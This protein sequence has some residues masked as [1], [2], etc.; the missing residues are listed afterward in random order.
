MASE[1][2]NVREQSLLIENDFVNRQLKVLGEEEEAINKQIL[3]LKT[4]YEIEIVKLQNSVS[5]LTIE[6]QENLMVIEELER[7]LEIG[8]RRAEQ[9]EAQTQTECQTLKAQYYNS[10][11]DDLDDQSDYSEENE[12]RSFSQ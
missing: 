1:L 6:K 8:Q 7:M 5:N 11:A 10:L 9:I 4:K 3:D 2:E 12:A